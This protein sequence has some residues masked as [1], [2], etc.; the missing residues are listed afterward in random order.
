VTGYAVNYPASLAADSKIKGGNDALAHLNAQSKACPDQKYVLVGYSQG[1]DVMHDTASKLDASL[2]SKIIAV[3]MF[4]D[5]GNKGPEAVSPQGGKVPVFPKDL[6][7]KLKQNCAAGDPV[8][9]NSGTEISAHLTYI[10]GDYM[11]SS[12]AYI[13]KQFQTGGKAG[14][15]PSANG[16]PK[17]KG[18]N[19]SVMQNL[20]SKLGKTP[21]GVPKAVLLD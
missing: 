13:Q 10:R 7:E 2:Y 9:T 6:Q 17:D 14:P 3:V 15:S 5:P 4:G 1:A 12:A 20:G 16:G 19:S 18:D 21:K 11:S 8:C